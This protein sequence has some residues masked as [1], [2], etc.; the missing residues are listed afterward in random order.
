ML[1][2]GDEKDKSNSKKG[3]FYY[4]LDRSKYRE[5]FQTVLNFIPKNNIVH[6]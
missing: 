3:A 1:I 5:Y 2:K 6:R 4:C